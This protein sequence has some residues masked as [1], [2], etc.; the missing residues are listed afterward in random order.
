M[1]TKKINLKKVIAL[2]EEELQKLLG[3]TYEEWKPCVNDA[4]DVTSELASGNTTTD[5]N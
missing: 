3:G 2:N 1:K 5:T 4:C